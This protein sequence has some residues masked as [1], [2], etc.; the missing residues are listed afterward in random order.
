M[1]T[2]LNLADYKV[3]LYSTTMVG[4]KSAPFYIN[5]TDSTFSTTERSR[6]DAYPELEEKEG[7]KRGH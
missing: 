7:G 4:G 2:F 3:Q 5:V 1:T 6:P